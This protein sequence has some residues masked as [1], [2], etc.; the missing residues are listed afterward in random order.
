VPRLSRFDLE[1]PHERRL[2]LLIERH[3]VDHAEVLVLAGDEERC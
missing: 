3:N 1:Q 2:I